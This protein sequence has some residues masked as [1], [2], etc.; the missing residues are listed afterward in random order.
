ME[1]PEHKQLKY[2]NQLAVV[3]SK[4]LLAQQD[5]IF[6]KNVVDLKSKTLKMEF[7]LKT[8]INKGNSYPSNISFDSL[9]ELLPKFEVNTY[10]DRNLGVGF[11]EFTII[12]EY[13]LPNIDAEASITEGKKKFMEKL[14]LWQLSS[15]ICAHLNTAAKSQMLK[16]FKDPRERKLTARYKNI[17]HNIFN[18][19]SKRNNKFNDYR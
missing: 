9:K 13:K 4:Y 12:R 14:F 7:V 2:P 19:F 15:C 11:G 17:I 16:R 8:K 5:D 6:S 3:L 10:G 1:V 18:R